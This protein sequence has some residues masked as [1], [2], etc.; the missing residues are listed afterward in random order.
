MSVKALG[1]TFELKSKWQRT[2]PS[3]GNFS[4]VIYRVSPTNP[5]IK[6]DI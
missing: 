5:N 6:V 2:V 3:F 4:W 1:N